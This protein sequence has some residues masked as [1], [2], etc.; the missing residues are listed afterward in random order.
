MTLSLSIRVQTTLNHIR[1]LTSIGKLGFLKICFFVVNSDSIAEY[2]IFIDFY[3][4][5]LVYSREIPRCQK[6]HKIVYQT[7]LNQPKF[8]S[9]ESYIG[10]LDRILEK[11]ESCAKKL[12]FSLTLWLPNFHKIAVFNVPLNQFFGCHDAKWTLVSLRKLFFTKKIHFPRLGT[13]R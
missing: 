10:R 5:S 4:A 1:L 3:L 8:C 12:C 2:C 6:M 9:L 13:K 11:A 7:T